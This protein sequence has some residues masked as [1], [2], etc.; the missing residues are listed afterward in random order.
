MDTECEK[1]P[2][3]EE[4]QYFASKGPAVRFF[5]AYLVIFMAGSLGKQTNCIGVWPS[6]N[7]RGKNLDK[8]FVKVSSPNQFLRLYNIVKAPRAAF[9]PSLLASPFLPI[10]EGQEATTVFPPFPLLCYVSYFHHELSLKF[11]CVK[12]REAL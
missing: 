8:T 4:S 12:S 11:W 5:K 9:S 10:T 2:N 7:T 3:F 1:M 6:L